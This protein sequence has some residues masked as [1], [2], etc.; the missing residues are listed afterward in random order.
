MEKIINKTF[1]WEGYNS[2]GKEYKFE[3]LTL[4]ELKDWA[5]KWGFK[6]KKIKNKTYVVS[7][8]NS[9]KMLWK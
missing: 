1:N 7:K 4:D 6:V 5:E 8:H 2:G 3:D 9:F